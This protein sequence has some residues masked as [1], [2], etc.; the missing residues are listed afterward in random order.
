MTAF[1]NLTQT[2]TIIQTK[3]EIKSV[4]HRY[5]ELTFKLPDSFRGIENN[6]RELLKKYVSRGRVDCFLQCELQKN[7]KDSLNINI[8]LVEK[9]AEGYNIILQTFQKKLQIN[10]SKF[11]A[12]EVLRWPLVLKEETTEINQAMNEQVIKDFET[13]LQKFVLQRQAEGEKLKEILLQRFNEMLILIENIQNRS[14]ATLKNHREKLLNKLK[15]L[16][17]E[18]NQERL[19]QELLYLATKL[20]IT[21]EIERLVIHINSG[22]NSLN[23]NLANGRQ[24]DFLAQ[25]LNR[26]VNTIASKATDS[27]ISQRAIELKVLIEK[28]REQVQNIE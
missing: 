11:S 6:L 23:Q 17:V 5:L 3:W 20:D 22:K 12:L 27:E 18:F 15:E 16:N 28:I 8:P 13:T 19:E 21:E 10:E 2:D 4:N 1:A 26:E 7:E 25:E 24:L 9:L 14:N